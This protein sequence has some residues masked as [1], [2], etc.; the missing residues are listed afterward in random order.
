MPRETLTLDDVS[1]I[2]EGD[3]LG[4]TRMTTQKRM[5]VLETDVIDEMLVPTDGGDFER[6]MTAGV[7]VQNGKTTRLIS[8]EMVQERDF[9]IHRRWQDLEESQMPA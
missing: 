4:K 6:E 9:E 5:P 1:E 8:Y 3:T 2:K 7:K